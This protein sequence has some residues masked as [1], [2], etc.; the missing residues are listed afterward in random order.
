MKRFWIGLGIVF[1]LGAGSVAVIAARYEPT[2]RPGTK[3]GPVD[4]GGLLP[5]EAEKKLRTWWETER[6]KSVSVEIEGRNVTPISM[7]PSQLGLAL[8]DTTSVKQVQLDDFWAS[9][10]RKFGSD[11]GGKNTYEVVFKTIDTDR[12]ALAEW[13]KTS[14]GENRPARVTFENGLIVRD[15]EV[16]GF[17]LDET[18]LPKAVLEAITSGQTVKV[19]ITEAP[20]NLPDSELEKIR[21][22][23]S[24]FSTTFPTGK[25]SRCA[26]IRLASSKI[27]GTV[28]MPGD[29]FSFNGIVGRRTREAGFQIAGVYKNGKHDVDLGGGICQVS[30]TLYNAAL[31]A[32][33][34]I[35]ERHNHS[36][37]VAYL[38]IGRDATLDYGTLDLKI[39]NNYDAP[40]AICADYQPGRLTFRILGTKVP[41]QT[42]RVFNSNV[43]SWG[44]GE[45]VVP[46]GSIPA[47]KRK[48]I[49]KGSAGH[50]CQTWRV[51]EI[52]G[53]E[54]KRESLGTSHYPGGQRVVAVGKAAPKSDSSGGTSPAPAPEP[55]PDNE[56]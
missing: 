1:G 33:L 31:M 10:K 52:D 45:K 13:V 51:V 53:K 39:Q 18:N 24:E 3:I 5:N 41:G 47:G 37:P 11:T 19:P 12:K 28:L 54:V 22:V 55:I 35:V 29:V 50:A 2:I 7:T 14:I 25:A 38:S 32:N 27:S 48:V 6:R 20:K 4:V 8:D 56:P 15:P 23:V 9:T 42:V 49:E 34:K 36:M 43:S 40:I 21:E 17:A 16:S 26:N 30:G 44:R 46:D